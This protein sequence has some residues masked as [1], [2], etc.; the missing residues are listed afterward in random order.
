MIQLFIIKN[1]GE[2]LILFS[3]YFHYVSVLYYPLMYVYV[4]V[5]S[6]WI[7]VFS[8]TK[9]YYPQLLLVTKR[10]DVCALEKSSFYV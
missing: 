7:N 4:Y 3:K 1:L 10:D 8:I 9:L 5:C 2:K 6:H